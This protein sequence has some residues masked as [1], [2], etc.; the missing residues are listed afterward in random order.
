MAYSLRDILFQPRNLQ[1]SDPAIPDKFDLQV[2]SSPPPRRRLPEIPPRFPQPNPDNPWG[3]PH[4]IDPPNGNPFN[5][6]GGPSVVTEHLSGPLE[7]QPAGGLPG[8]LRRAMMLQS[9]Q[10]GGNF[11]STPDGAREY[12]P[13]TSFSPQG[14]LLGRLLSLQA[15]QSRYQPFVEDSGQPRDPN[16]R[17]LSQ[18]PDVAPSPIPSAPVSRAE[19]V[20]PQTQYEADQAQQ[21]R[22]AAAARLA[23]GVR[24]P[25]RTEG[26][27]PDP[28][29]IA[30]SAGVG[31]ANGAI[32]AA[33]LPGAVL[34]GFGHLP[35]NLV[36]NRFRRAAGYPDLPADAPDWIAERGTA[37]PIRHWVEKH[38]TGEFYEP[39]SR[40]GRF[41]ETVGE[42]A[43]M[44]VVGE[45]AGVARGVQTA[46]EALRGLP[47][48]LAKHA[49][50]PGI[51]V[52]TLKEALPD[53]RVGETVQRGY[54]VVR[55]T[56]P[57]VL[58]AK[59]YLSRR[60]AP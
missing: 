25:A 26:P 5:F 53:S 44:V 8:M 33:G 11:G 58:A 14:G 39:K 31:L 10:Q 55:R 50:A 4:Y 27:P 19:V 38:L 43:P 12:N 20:A 23:R 22:E 15:E 49:V 54:P 47:G 1:L 37:E 2:P 16:F 28:I 30:K 57:V 32:N 9:Q 21:A 3:D 29:D 59:Q 42:M 34:T 6:P 7:D 45:A 51:A 40:I 24:S 13:E 52:Q 46:G 18:V 60:T 48:I 56:L 41:A 35:N 17:Q 36:A